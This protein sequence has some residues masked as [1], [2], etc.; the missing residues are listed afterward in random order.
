MSGDRDADTHGAGG[1]ETPAS[2]GATAGT[3]RARIETTHDDSE[4]AQLLARALRPD[5]TAEMETRIE[6]DRLVTTVH[7]ETTGGLQSTADDYIVNLQTATQVVTEA[8]RAGDTTHE[9][10]NHNTD[11]GGDTTSRNT[12]E[13][14]SQGT[15]PGETE[16]QDT[17]RDTET[18]NE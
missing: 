1:A 3:R 15:V 6:G 18:D 10:R 13:T 9:K 14:D 12:S 7:R 8:G 5:N 17:T 4:T 16:P 11:S 2:D